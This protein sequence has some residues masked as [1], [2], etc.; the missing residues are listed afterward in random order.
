MLH[1]N[2]M[3]STQLMNMFLFLFCFPMIDP[4]SYFSFQRVFS[5]WCNTGHGMCYPFCGMVHIKNG[6]HEVVAADFLSH[7]L[8]SHLSYVQCH[9]TVNKMH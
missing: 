1:C 4:L 5:N 8:N 6:A 3:V 2:I 9:I 7:Y